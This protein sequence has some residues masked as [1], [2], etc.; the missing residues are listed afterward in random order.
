MA[1]S[2]TCSGEPPVGTKGNP[3]SP[4]DKVNGKTGKKKKNK[5]RQRPACQNATDS[6][7]SSVTVEDQSKQTKKRSARSKQEKSAQQTS[8]RSNREQSTQTESPES[9]QTQIETPSDQGIHSPATE[10]KSTQ[11]LK[12]SFTLHQAYWGK[13]ST[14]DGSVDELAPQSISISNQLTVI[15]WNID[16]LDLENVYSR[17]KGLLSHLGNCK[18]N[19]QERLN[20]LRRVWKWMKEAPLDHT[21]IF[22]GD[23]NLRDWEVKKLGGL[24]NG[25]FDVWEM[26]GE[27]E[28]SRYTWDTSINDNKE[29][30][31][32]IRIRFDRL[33]F[34][35]AGAQDTRFFLGAVCLRLPEAEIMHTKE[36]SCCCSFEDCKL[37]TEWLLSRTRHRPKIAIVCGSGLGLLAENA[38][39]KQDVRYEDIPN[40][41]FLVMRGVLYLVT[42]KANPVSS[43]KEGFTST[44]VIQCAR[45]GIRF[46]CMSDAYSKALRK[47]ALD[48]T[49]ELG[50]SN[51]VREGVYCMVS[52]PNFETIAEARML[53]ILGSDSVGM[54]TVPEVTVAKH[55]GLSVLGLS[56]ITNKVSLDYSREEKVNHEEVL[57][58]SKMRAEMLQ[59]VLMT[60]IARSHQV[61]PI[62]N[63]NPNAV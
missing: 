53:H 49:A 2:H 30:P 48:I 37:T 12:T 62:N 1:K 55:C 33:F 11:T 47:L 23:T 32:S 50:Y 36:N 41:P 31:N 39:N 63:N 20:Q 26:L 16:G 24:P 44:R 46:P 52:G 21:V 35:P 22:G 54:S 42:S 40:F 58:I 6:L 9:V 57:Q 28:E 17:S 56:L 51:F 34:R 43:C 38:S 18:A 13:S 60:F 7:C 19:S 25:I 4:V 59:N 5:R 15:S 14:D 3:S 45:F 29:I 27:P 10:S 8:D 61:D